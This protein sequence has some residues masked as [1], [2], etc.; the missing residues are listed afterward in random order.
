MRESKEIST[1]AERYCFVFHHHCKQ[2]TGFLVAH[3]EHNCVN[4]LDQATVKTDRWSYPFLGEKNDQ[5]KS[6]GTK[7]KPIHSVLSP[8][9]LRFCRPLCV[10]LVSVSALL[11]VSVCFPASS[12]LCYPL[13]SLSFVRPFPTD[14]SAFQRPHHITSARR[15]CPPWFS[16]S[17]ASVSFENARLIA[18][19]T[20]QHLSKRRSTEQEITFIHFDLCMSFI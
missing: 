19:C 1:H 11:R 17:T 13:H 8:L 15:S 18:F 4:T 2:V 5:Q 20:H 16:S 10:L 3:W 9:S 6:P 14:S 12:L 7:V